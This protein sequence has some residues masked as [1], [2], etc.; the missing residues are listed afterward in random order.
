MMKYA[1][2]IV[3]K[4]GGGFDDPLF[5]SIP[6]EFLELC[7]VGSF[8]RIPFSKQ[9][10]H[11]VVVD[12]KEIPSSDL[13]DKIKEIEEV[14]PG[15]ALGIFEI[16]TARWMASYYHTSLL[17][18]LR[19]FVPAKLWEGQFKLPEAGPGEPLPV[20]PLE[21]LELKLTSEQEVALNQIRSSVKPA[22]LQGV[23]GS[24]KTEVYLR[25][26]LETL[27]AGKQ[28]ILLVPEIALTPQMQDYFKRCFGEHMAVF[29]SRLTDRQRLAAWLQVKQGM[30][31][32]VIGSRSA[33]FA[34]AD[35]LGLIIIDEEHEWT[36]KQES[37]PYYETHQVAEKLQSLFKCKLV[38]ASATP[39]LESYFKAQKGT[40]ERILM[41]SR[42]HQPHLPV[43]QLADL[44][45]EFKK[46]NFSLFSLVLQKKIR[47][48]L[49]RKEQILLFV[50]QRGLARAVVCRDCGYTENCPHCEIPLKYHRGSPDRLMCHYCS[51]ASPPPVLCPSCGSHYIRYMG[52]GTQRV[53][54]EVKKLFPLARAIRADRDTTKLGEGFKPIYQAFHKGDYDIL[55]GTQMIAKGLDFPRVSLIGIVLADI[56]MHVPDFRS[57][58]RLF[59][60]L[61]QV[62]GRAGRS[63][64]SPGEVVLQTYVPEHFAIAAAAKHGYQEFAEQ[65]LKNRLRYGYPPFSRLIKFTVVGTD[66]EHLR[67]H[68]KAEEETLQDIVRVNELPLKVVSA[69]AMMP[70]VADRYYYHVL[71]RGQEPG[72]LFNHW[73]LPKGWRVDIDP[74]HT[75]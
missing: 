43:V 64:E 48:T 70:R 23:T 55:I 14:I 8:V 51:F 6:P 47:E 66:L 49:L 32:L 37:A 36:Y 11:G 45:E 20:F 40:Y 30:A 26:I 44:R 15:V 2:V 17:K 19:F 3:C 72:R 54:E 56:G 61:T 46:K 71:V 59:Q 41:N 42:I 65:E 25:L 67:H 73:K 24:G 75:A 69:P 22:L 5:Y 62:A 57:H 4:K 63:K 50:N 58:E 38:L 27:Q 52:V 53:E 18:A 12:L 13:K 35:R 9:K 60:L 34:P 39:R 21:P 68:I 16:E 7:Q 31:P 1:T 33:I 74:I 28:A 10:A 29:H